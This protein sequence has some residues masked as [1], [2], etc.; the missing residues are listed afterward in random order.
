MTPD[1]TFSTAPTAPP[2]L[3]TPL[4]QTVTP[5][6]TPWGPPQDTFQPSPTPPHG[7]ADTAA[8]FSQMGR[9][10]LGKPSFGA[11]VEQPVVTRLSNGAEAHLLSRP[12][13]KDA[14]V[15]FS[16]PLNTAV[17]PGPLLQ[18][19]LLNCS[20]VSR[21]VQLAFAE[22]GVQVS[23]VSEG[24]RAHLC[25]TGPKGQEPG[26]VA[27]GLS[28]MREPLMDPR[29]YRM[30]QNTLDA[31]LASI[32]KDPDVRLE[33]TL[34]KH[35]FGPTH[36]YSVSSK[37]LQDKI[38]TQ[39]LDEL[40]DRFQQAVADPTQVRLQV[41]SSLP[42]TS[43]RQALES[44][45][46]QHGWEKSAFT[47]VPLPQQ[48]PEAKLPTPPRP[49]AAVRSQ[50]ADATAGGS[51]L[52]LTPDES[53]SRFHLLCAW[54]APS[55]HDDDRLT[56]QLLTRV[57]SGMSGPLFETLRTQMGLV[58]STRSQYTPLRDTGVF[59][60]GAEIDPTQDP[61]GRSKITRSLEE[62]D[63]I[64]RRYATTPLDDDTLNRAK[65]E[66]LLEFRSKSQTAKGLGELNLANVS[67][68]LPSLSLQQLEA[69]LA[70]ITPQ[71]VQRVARETFQDS[72]AGIKAIS[73]PANLLK[74]L[75]PTPQPQPPQ[76]I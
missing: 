74:L 15:V 42:P 50:G 6:P 9:L 31:N 13:V 33:E 37:E 40:K 66:L 19:A 54:P 59:T 30:I 1:V 64:T 24:D 58:Y 41:T 65:R 62:I 60:I 2:R 51:Q 7:G 49:G 26:M 72:T 25:L 17:L 73:G 14:H 21:S 3:V 44:A 11:G 23:L 12:D 53:L 4:G 18:P 27:L 76:N 32:Q 5:Q 63:A 43:M 46:K 39:A 8:R 35:L 36:P 38:R 10:S 57:M 70:A 22:K 29:V 61:T 69:K 55:L 16:L 48:L 52:L 75:Q 20:P 28:L 68:G 71:D 67:V 34:K 45:I 56:F 47:D